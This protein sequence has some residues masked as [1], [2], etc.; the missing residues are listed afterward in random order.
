[1]SDFI[2]FNRKD[3]RDY[4]SMWIWIKQGVCLEST[5]SS[6]Y[7]YTQVFIVSLEWLSCILWKINQN[8]KE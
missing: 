5:H 6:A 7:V 3:N 2:L 4:Y 8:K 1:M